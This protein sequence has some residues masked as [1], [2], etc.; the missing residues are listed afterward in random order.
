MLS[1]STSLGFSM[2]H[3]TET[4]EDT[5]DRQQVYHFYDPKVVHPACGKYLGLISDLISP[6]FEN[7]ELDVDMK[8]LFSGGAQDVEELCEQAGSVLSSEP[9]IIGV[10]VRRHDDLVIVSDIHGQYYD[11]LFSMLSV[12]LEKRRGEMRDE[13]HISTPGKRRDRDRDFQ[14]SRDHSLTSLSSSFSKYENFFAKGYKFLFLGD[15]VD[16]G[17]YSLEVIVLLLALKVEYPNNVFLLRGNHEVGEVCR[18]YGFFNECQ[19]KLA[20]LEGS[21]AIAS[22]S[23][24]A[25]ATETVQS[26]A[27]A[28]WYRFTTVFQWLPVGAV[29]R[30]GAGYCFCTHGGL[31]PY[32]QSI[33]SLAYMKREE[34]APSEGIPL[35]ISPQGSCS[36][37]AQDMA[38]FTMSGGTAWSR[39]RTSSASP[40]R[41]TNQTEIIN[42]LL[43]SD[44][45]ENQR[46]CT[47]S[48]RGCGYIFGEDVTAQFL[49]MNNNLKYSPT[50]H[51]L[52][53]ARRADTTALQMLPMETKKVHFVIRGHQCVANGYEWVHKGRLLTLFSA[54]NYCGLSGN[55]GCIAI[56][57]GAAHD[58]VSRRCDKI[59][60]DF[61]VY[62]SYDGFKPKYRS[63][64]SVQR[65][66]A[67]PKNRL[68]TPSS[69]SRNT[70]VLG[71][72]FS[73]DA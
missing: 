36:N 26:D 71:T 39:M 61:K 58:M 12:Q 69:A 68:L 16:R 57:H 11:L 40:N 53:Q 51:Q 65:I 27:A 28:L 49:L 73:D 72:Y 55:K 70:G 22:S 6:F 41:V 31:S 35:E 14:S 47:T 60:L 4:A 30:C 34:Y 50:V 44:P 33:D 3:F 18:M 45:S 21:V 66:P 1:S 8:T 5:L 24:S 25:S 54:P 32:T 46:G 17:A 10:D 43:W 9:P 63:M 23:P 2:Y 59:D 7:T 19:A 13:E 20:D 42:G 64:G 52:S 37:L 56:L 48:A 38:A 29:I 15:Y 62:D 67:A